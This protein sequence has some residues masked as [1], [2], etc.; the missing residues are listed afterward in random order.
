LDGPGNV[1]AA[2]R[3]AAT[4]WAMDNAVGVL[5]AMLDHVWAAVDVAKTETSRLDAFR[6]PSTGP[7]ATLVQDLVILLMLPVRDWTLALRRSVDLEPASCL[8]NKAADPVALLWLALGEQGALLD[9][10]L[11]DPR[12]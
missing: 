8:A 1:L 12:I 3:V 9:S 6:S 7:V 4:P 11:N 2:I 10:L 5:V